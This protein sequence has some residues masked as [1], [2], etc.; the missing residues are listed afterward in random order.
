[1]LQLWRD[2]GD[3]KNITFVPKLLRPDFSTKSAGL[4]G[5]C[6]VNL[7]RNNFG[8]K[9]IFFEYLGYI[10]YCYVLGPELIFPT[11]LVNFVTTVA[12]LVCLAL[13]G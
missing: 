10:H 13:F 6:G 7:G 5:C 8:I 4:L 9:V 3:S 11:G 1:M 2:L 12:R